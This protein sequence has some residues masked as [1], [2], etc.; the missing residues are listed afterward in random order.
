MADR[1]GSG[2]G[3]IIGSR[4]RG[5][6]EQDAHHFPYL[7]FCGTAV[8]SHSLF[9]LFGGMLHDRKAYKGQREH[10]YPARLT[11]C[12]GRTSISGEEQLFYGRFKWREGRNDCTEALL[13]KM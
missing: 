4:N 10:S 2:I 3:G 8:P 1:H 11:N 7:I 6:F 12:Y 5:K 13:Q 9:N